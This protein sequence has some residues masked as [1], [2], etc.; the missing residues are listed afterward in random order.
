MYLVRL[1]CFF[2]FCSN[3]VFDILKGVYII[4][5]IVGFRYSVIIL[6]VLVF[7]FKRISIYLF[8]IYLGFVICSFRDIDK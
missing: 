1:F 8:Y 2:D 3:F 7:F 5:G 4:E 6:G